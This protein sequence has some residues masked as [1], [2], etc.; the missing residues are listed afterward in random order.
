[1][2][3]NKFNKKVFA[4][5][6]E[7]AK[8]E[9]SWRRFAQDCG[10]SYIQMLKLAK[11]EQE[12]SPRPK[13]IDKLAER[14]ENGIEAADFYF[15]AGLVADAEDKGSEGASLGRRF[16]ALSPSRRRAVSEYVE[17]LY[18]KEQ[19]KASNALKEKDKCQ[20]DK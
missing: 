8:G 1:M 17:F 10:I 19:E 16:E 2:A 18:S 12:N 5:L 3:H 6:L 14:S 13:L 9:R 11:C 7:K 15:A 20:N 4:V